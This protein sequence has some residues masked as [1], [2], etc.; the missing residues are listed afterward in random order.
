MRTRRTKI[1]IVHIEAKTDWQYSRLVISNFSFDEKKEVVINIQNPHDLAR[2][3][4]EL[5][6]I[7]TR[8]REELDSLR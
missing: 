5:T 7:E 6:K 4:R 2:I 1:T 8:W 3:R